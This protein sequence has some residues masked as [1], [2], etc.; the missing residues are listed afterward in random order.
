[1]FLN[2]VTAKKKEIGQV[3]EH[4]VTIVSTIGRNKEEPMF[5]HVY[6]KVH[7]YG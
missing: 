1:M 5:T 6:V 3:E 7:G 2:S 4:E